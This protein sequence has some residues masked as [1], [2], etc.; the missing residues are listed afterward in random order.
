MAFISKVYQI[1]L[2]MHTVMPTGLPIKMTDVVLGRTVF[3]MALILSVG[4][5]N[6][7][8]LLVAAVLNHNTNHFP[9]QRQN[10]IGSNPYSMICNSLCQPVQDY[11]AII[12]VQH[13]FPLIQSSMQELN[14]LKWIFTMSGIKSW[15]INFRSYFYLQ[16]S[17]LL[18]Y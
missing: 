4:V 14:I 9:T 17:N 15:Q 1:T 3:F 5:V 8:K 16:S 10:Y 7:N 12:L 2:S 11:G 13:I 18:I 6:S